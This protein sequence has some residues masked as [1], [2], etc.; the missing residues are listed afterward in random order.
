MGTLRTITIIAAALL[1]ASTCKKSDETGAGGGGAGGNTTGSP[2]CEPLCEE[3]STSGCDDAPTYDGCMLTCLSL[4][5]SSA[6]V[7]SANDYFDCADAT[8]VECA[9]WGDPYFPGCG[10]EWLVAIDCAVTENPNPAIQQPCGDYCD[11]VEALGC[12]FNNPRDECYTN[13][14][15]LGNTGTGCDDEWATYLDCAN[16]VTMECL[17]GFA[18]APGCG[19]DWDAYWQCIN[20]VGN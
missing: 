6:C 3:L 8:S 5:S 17:L 15:W 11:T 1:A 20:Q 18:V 9:S 12:E 16:G 10:D 13:C 7:P 14:L 4:T 19:P 2:N